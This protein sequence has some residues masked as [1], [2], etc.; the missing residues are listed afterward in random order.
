MH[1]EWFIDGANVFVEIY[2]DRI[3]VVSPGGLLQGLLLYDLGSRSVRR[4]TLVADLLHR[5]GFIEKAETGIRRIRNEAR[6]LH[7]PEPEF[8]ATSFFVATF[9]PSPEV[10]ART[11][12]HTVGQVTTEFRLLQAISGGLT[13]QSIRDALGLKNDEYF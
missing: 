12:V 1:R 4:Y 10:Q 2:V 7:C 11:D 9:G 3:E 5:I 6:E 8:Q 13:R